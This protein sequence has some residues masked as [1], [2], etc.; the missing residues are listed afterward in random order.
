[1]AITFDILK[2][3]AKIFQ[4][5]KKN[6]S[7]WAR[8]KNDSS[9][10]IEIR[11][12]NQVNVYFE[13][14]SVARIH[15]CS[16]HKKL[17]VF[18]HHKYLNLPAPS[19]RNAYIECSGIIDEPKE[20]NSEI[21]VCDKVIERVKTCYSQKHAINGIVDKEKWSEKFIQGTLITQSSDFHLD[22]E[23]AYNDATD[24]N[25]IDLIRCD[26]GVI[27]FVELKRIADGRML[28]KTD[29]SPEIVDQMNRYKD[30]ITKYS[31]ELLAYYQKLYD[32]KAE[33]GLPVPQIRPSSINPEPHLLIFDNWT[34][35]TTGRK[36]HRERLI[37]ILNREKI[38]FSIQTDL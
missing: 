17:Q 5:L 35:E 10:Y 1:M 21:L 38:N 27:T 19:K 24:K 33:L 9:L 29:E 26:N 2:P 14:G 31:V 30:F 36:I 23:F 37:D 18:T 4:E 13:G 28:H 32:V 34:K 8:F 12:D 15:Y 3:E 7:W 6:P 22:S 11:K 20:T 25:R 16:K